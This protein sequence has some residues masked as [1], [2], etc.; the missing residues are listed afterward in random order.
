[1]TF[2]IHLDFEDNEDI[3]ISYCLDFEDVLYICGK[4]KVFYL[5][6]GEQL[7][8]AT[9]CSRE[10]VCEAFQYVFFTWLCL[11]QMTDML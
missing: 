3:M 8:V 11:M 10:S 7:C 1:M 6:Y 4:N 9:C 5:Q 2:L